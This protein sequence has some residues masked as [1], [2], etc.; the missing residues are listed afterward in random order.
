MRKCEIEGHPRNLQY[1]DVMHADARKML[2]IAEVL[3][4]EA[5]TESIGRALVKFTDF[6][7]SGG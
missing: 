5:S 6:K 1:V 2:F 3:A 7:F 4:G